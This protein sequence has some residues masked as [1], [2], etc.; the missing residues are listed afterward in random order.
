MS[1]EKILLVL[2]LDE[3]LV[4]VSEKKLDVQEDFRYEKYFVYCRPALQKFLNLISEH[5]RLA[6][7]SSAGEEYLN[8][9]VSKITPE[10]IN[11]EFIWSRNK[12]TTRRDYITDS[13][14]F[15]K[16]LKKLKKKYNLKKVLIVDDSPEKTRD[17]YGNAI[18]ITPF[19]GDIKDNVLAT[20]ADYLI[21][22]KDVDN[23]RSIEKRGWNKKISQ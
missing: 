18:Y 10:N 14:V 9:I 4:H 12:C 19:E 6:I 13:Y 20:L 21:S 22:I 2:D 16:R 7:W 5:F 1:N 17:N 8:E 11:F 15:E 3:T 23:V